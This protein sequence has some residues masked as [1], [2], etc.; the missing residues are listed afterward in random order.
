MED[1]K[2]YYHAFERAVIQ[3]LFVSNLCLLYNL[4]SLATVRQLLRMGFPENRLDIFPK[5]TLRLCC[6]LGSNGSHLLPLESV[7]RAKS[8]MNGVRA[9]SVPV[10]FFKCLLNE[11]MALLIPLM[12]RFFAAGVRGV[13]L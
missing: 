7:S 8:F 10:P 11:N 3:K 12:I 13:K 5:L 2:R 1:F 4:V 9:K 6:F